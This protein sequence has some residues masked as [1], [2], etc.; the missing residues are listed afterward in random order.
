MAA[1]VIFLQEIHLNEL[2]KN[3]QKELGNS[4]YASSRKK[5]QFVAVVFWKHG[6]LQK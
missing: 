4:A 1:D 2:H 5:N 6:L 3:L